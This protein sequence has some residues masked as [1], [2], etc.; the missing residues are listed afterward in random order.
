MFRLTSAQPEVTG[1]RFVL[2]WFS[3]MEKKLEN[4]EKKF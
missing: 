3:R 1:S 4:L 2:F